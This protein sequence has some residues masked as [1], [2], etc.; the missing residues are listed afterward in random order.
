MV[1]FS[2]RGFRDCGVKGLWF[3]GFGKEGWRFLNRRVR[4]DLVVYF[5]CS[6]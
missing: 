1:G 5:F 4:W 3:L 6:F 2:L